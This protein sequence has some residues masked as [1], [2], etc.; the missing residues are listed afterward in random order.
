MTARE[1][2]TFNH[3]PISGPINATLGA[4]LLGL[5]GLATDMPSPAPLLPTLA[6]ATATYVFGRRLGTAPSIV[7]FR[8]GCFL[9]AG[10]W[11]VWLLKGG[12]EN[13]WVWTALPSVA[14]AAGILSPAF[15]PNAVSAFVDPAPDEGRAADRSEMAAEWAQRILSLTRYKVKIVGIEAWPDDTGYTFDMDPPPGVTWKNLAP[16]GQSLAGAA[17]LDLG[18]T[19][20]FRVGVNQ[21]A[22]LM[23]VMTVNALAVEAPFPRD[24]RPTSVNDPKDIGVYKNGQKVYV[25]FRQDSSLT[26]GEKGSGKTTVL[27]TMIGKCATNVDSISVV[28]D[29]NAGSL[30]MPFLYPLAMGVVKKAVIGAVAD[31][32]QEGIL[33]VQM[34]IDIALDRKKSAFEV[35]R[36][37]NATLLPISRTLP[38]FEVFVDEGAEV[39]GESGPSYQLRALL[40]KLQRVGRDSGFNVHFTGLRGTGDVIPPGIRAQS[41]VRI[42]ATVGGDE[43]IAYVMGWNRNL[44]SDDLQYPGNAFIRIKKAP[45]VQYMGYNLKPDQIVELSSAT[46]HHHPDLDPRALKIAGDR[47][48][49]RW[50]RSRHI[51]ISLGMPDD[52]HGDDDAPVSAGKVSGEPLDINSALG[53]AQAAAEKLMRITGRAA[54]GKRGQEWFDAQLDQIVDGFEVEPAS[55]APTAEPTFSD[56]IQAGADD[57]ADRTGTT[58]DEALMGAIIEAATNA[59]KSFIVAFVHSFGA[60]GVKSGKIG[61]AMDREGMTVHRDTR[62]KYLAELVDDGVL[63]KPGVQGLYVHADFVP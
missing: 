45:P 62:Q 26:I 21:G 52:S 27:T 36:Q 58:G 42:C 53:A 48:T 55:T 39:V 18:C 2:G 19:V 7:W 17:K 50:H 51:L 35:K 1:V 8:I 43:E 4:V 29:L 16:Y 30:A 57:Y 10:A 9:A 13:F 31:N 59:P 47:W 40:E 6:A 34:L 12:P 11:V 54:V 33:L 46:E 5:L 15:T 63:C 22:V 37:A 25:G 56:L 41:S 24:Y 61:E 38:A 3:G 20:T 49:K 14:L 32:V 28:I 60:D 23:D 44:S